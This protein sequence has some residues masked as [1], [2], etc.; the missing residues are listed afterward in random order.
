[1]A[2]STPSR[3]ER[4]EEVTRTRRQIAV[5]ERELQAARDNLA[6]KRLAF[7]EALVDAKEAGYSA[8]AIAEYADGLSHQRVNQLI[9]SQQE[10]S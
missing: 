3:L 7:R 6:A 8:R 2:R 10:D 5:A 1:M 4:L 9:R